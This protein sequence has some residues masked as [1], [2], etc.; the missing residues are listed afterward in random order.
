MNGASIAFTLTETFALLAELPL[1]MAST[2]VCHSRE[3]GNPGF[4][5]F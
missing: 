2:P 1:Q 5:R 4:L 3:N